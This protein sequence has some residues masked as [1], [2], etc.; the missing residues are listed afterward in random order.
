MRLFDDPL[1][2]RFLTWP[3]NI[4]GGCGRVTG[5]RHALIAYI[6]HRWPGVRTSVVARTRLID[7]TITASLDET[8]T[9]VVLLG[10]GFDSRAYR[11]PSLRGAL[12]FEVDHPDTQRAKRMVLD[13]AWRES[14]Q[15]VRYVPCDFTAHALE[16]AMASAGYREGV[17][18]FI[19]WEGVTNY[20]SEGDVDV[21]LRWC[22]RAAPGSRVL[23]T[24]VHRDLFTRPESFVGTAQLF[25]S[26]E[27]AGER[28]TWGIEPD[29]LAAFLAA[30][31]LALESDVGA[32][33]YRRRAFGESSRRMR[34]HEFYRVAVARVA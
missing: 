11:L 16:S 34:G 7:E 26:L 23:F 2:Q 21:T 13:R 17:P 24:Y 20:L 4:A 27:K 32:A 29:A 18:T 10:A 1:A 33:E 14:R 30:R 28:M 25:A 9:Q 31:G 8:I 5:L 15:H 6:D 3:L 12:V 22:A 19:L